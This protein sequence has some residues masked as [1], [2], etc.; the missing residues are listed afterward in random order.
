MISVLCWKWGK[1][2]SAVYV[3]RLRSMLARHLRIPHRLYCITDDRSGLDP[4]IGC[5]AMPTWLADTPRCRRR[6]QQFSGE[7]DWIFGPR[8]LSI[9]L[10]V[11]I[12]DDI[13]PLVD[14][15][16]PIVGWRVGYADVI[17]G[18]LLLW[19]ANALDGL[20]RTYLADRE[21]YPLRAQPKGVGSDQAM[22][23]LWLKTQ[24]PIAEW[25]ERDGIVSYF[26]TGYERFEHLGVG[27]N[28]Q[29][30]PPGARIVVL[31]SADKAAMDN[32]EAPWIVENWK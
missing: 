28:Q 27:P 23:N 26:G 15:P 16:E 8:I 25:T 24:P 19:D 20:W 11:V 9:D 30:L 4:E 2:F 7:F 17:C 32:G 31:G 29:K 13:T 12:V 3:N 21:G 5:F 6:M 22:L 1:L 14:R 18:S 10:D